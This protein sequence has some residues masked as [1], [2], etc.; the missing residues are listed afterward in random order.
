M[1]YDKLSRALRYYYEKN[2]IRKVH[3]HKFVY[4]FMG[5]RNL[6]KICQEASSN[7][8]ST[9]PPMEPLL[10]D[11]SPTDTKPSTDWDLPPGTA[12]HMDSS[13]NCT[14]PQ[15]E[16]SVVTSTAVNN[17]NNTSER[18]G[19]LIY[20]QNGLT[21]K[22][23]ARGIPTHP[24][25]GIIDRWPTVTNQS[26]GSGNGGITTTVTATATTNTIQ[27]STTQ[28]NPSPGLNENSLTQD[29][30]SKTPPESVE[31]PAPFTLPMDTRDSNPDVEVN[32]NQTSNDFSNLLCS[33]ASFMS[34]GQW[35]P[36]CCVNSKNDWTLLKPPRNTVNNIT[37]SNNVINTSS[38]IQNPEI[39]LF[40]TD[41]PMS[42]LATPSL[43]SDSTFPSL[44]N[45]PINL[46]R[47]TSPTKLHHQRHAINMQR[48][49]E[50]LSLISRNCHSHS[51]A[52]STPVVQ[53]N[54]ATSPGLVSISTNSNS[55]NNSGNSSGSSNSSSNG[56][57][58]AN[59]HTGSL[60]TARV[61]PPGLKDTVPECPKT[62]QTFGSSMPDH[63]TRFPPTA[64]SSSSGC[65]P[66]G[67]PCVWMPVPVTMLTSWIRLLS[68]M[69]S[70]GGFANQPGDLGARRTP[71]SRQPEPEANT[72]NL[73]QPHMFPLSSVVEPF[74]GL[75]SEPR[76]N[77]HFSGV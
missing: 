49:G 17:L 29:G 77:D 72:T 2:I 65:S 61:P 38:T 34:A 25:D 3:G 51:I 42:S 13:P 67:E 20:A 53:G 37:S 66:N 69:T 8:A 18:L 9:R 28:N 50:Q 12:L 5:L 36:L 10:T 27:R 44:S 11:C 43:Q 15:N 39:V 75:K 57:T 46:T 32:T 23:G 48:L 52:K 7:A 14:C 33:L 55:S 31:H 60:S 26:D 35:M 16:D 54:S 47:E 22:P 30:H 40:P 73:I 19:S 63:F 56:S 41:P 45:L 76:D 71:G 64:P 74:A 24:L 58:A 68:G 4:Q 70:P 59:Q 6:I 62:M 21:T 1:N